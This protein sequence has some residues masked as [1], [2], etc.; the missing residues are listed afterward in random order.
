MKYLP[1]YSFNLVD[2][3]VNRIRIEKGIEKDPTLKKS[4]DICE[5]YMEVGKPMKAVR[6][7]TRKGIQ[8]P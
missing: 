6:G 8:I 1:N 4:R 2:L 3:R 5:R 7:M